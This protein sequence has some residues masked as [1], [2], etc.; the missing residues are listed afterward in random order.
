MNQTVETG[1]VTDINAD[2]VVIGGGIAGLWLF[3]TLNKQGYKALLLEDETL[4]GGQTI[5]SQG[6][7]HGGTKYTLSGNLTKAADCIAGMP[8]RWRD[9]LAGQGDVDLSDAKVLSEYHYLWSPGD[10]ASRMTSFFASKA[11]R[12]RVNQVKERESLPAIFC[13]DS[14]RGTVYKLNEIV[15]DIQT[16]VKSL[17]RGLESRTLKVDWTPDSGDSRLVTDNGEIAFIEHTQGNVTYRIHARKFVLT[18]GEGARTLMG[19]WGISEPEMQLRPLHMV[20]VKHTH[21][22]P[23]YAH[24]LGIKTVPRMTVTSHPTEDGQWVWYLGGEIAEDGVERTPEEQIRVARRELA[25]I[26]PWVNFDNAQWSTLRVNRAE[27]KQSRLLRP[28]AAFCQPVGNGIVTWPT[29]LALAPN[30]AD[31]VGNLLG[32][33]SIQPSG[34]EEFA[35]P[36]TLKHPQVCE[37]FWSKHFD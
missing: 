7:V 26:L 2:V 16:V 15:L 4:G 17:V 24:C 20:M 37:Q 31:E 6:I 34:N 36:A 1:N 10:I 33:D 29:K 18:A 27:P 5:K 28:D 30:L 3:N 12:G 32:A 25:D 9:A 35:L 8:Q 23:L 14:F 11:L 13:N 21:P 22:D 19:R